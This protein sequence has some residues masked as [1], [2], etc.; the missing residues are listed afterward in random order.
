MR[1]RTCALTAIAGV[2]LAGLVA[3]A[4]A[5]AVYVSGKQVLKDEVHYKM[6]GDL[7]GS[8]KITNF[9]VVSEGPVFKAKGKEKFKGCI[10]GNRDKSCA[11]DVTGKL[12]FKFTYWARFADDG[13]IQLGTCAH[14]VYD[15]TEAFNGASGFLMMVDTPSGNAAGLKT[16]YE[17]EITPQENK[18][19]VPDGPGSC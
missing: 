6:K 11:G 8:W 19:A 13:A 16:H 7:F 3:A 1:I 9:K 12:F 2:A 4:P 17:G 14:R 10:D 18:G 5:G 15:G